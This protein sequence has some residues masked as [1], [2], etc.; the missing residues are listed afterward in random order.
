MNSIK[1]NTT[2]Q[3]F[4]VFARL[5]ARGCLS[6]DLRQS[7]HTSEYT[8]NTFKVNLSNYILLGLKHLIMANS[9]STEE[10]SSFLD[11]TMAEEIP[12]VL[13]FTFPDRTYN[14]MPNPA[15]NLLSKAVI[16]DLHSRGVLNTKNANSP[17]N[18][19]CVLTQLTRHVWNR[20]NL[21][22]H[23]DGL[24]KLED[25]MLHDDRKA[26]VQVVGVSHG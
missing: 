26:R 23:S 17:D 22:L 4:I 6:E 25:A 18:I 10:Y 11:S 1:E 24:N 20:S 19:A 5:S 15:Y 2:I 3:L 13:D 8:N 16:D 14:W 9:N 21:W 7:I 12:G